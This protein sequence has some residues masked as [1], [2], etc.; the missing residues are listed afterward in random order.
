MAS[1]SRQL[2][3]RPQAQ[4]A[5][6]RPAALARRD[7]R[8]PRTE[9]LDNVGIE[10]ALERLR[11][12]VR[13]TGGK[14]SEVRETIAKAALSIDGHFRVEALAELL[15]G[16]SP[17]TVYRVLPLLIEAGLIK[18]APGRAEGQLYERAFET[19]QHSHLVCVRCGLVI[20]VKHQLLEQV[21]REVAKRFNFALE[22]GSHVHQ[23]NGLCPNCQR[24][25]QG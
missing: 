9:H 13:Q 11:E 12:H 16:T 10:R 24:A 3:A 14:G 1:K 20:E 2:P 5:L 7:R 21:N 25:A 19:E 17:A 6:R 15:P 8:A 18:E 23:L 4:R 22:K